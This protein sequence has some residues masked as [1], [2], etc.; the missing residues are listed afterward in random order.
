MCKKERI[1]RRCMCPGKMRWPS[2]SEP[3]C[4]Y[5]RKHN[6]SMPAG[7]GTTTK[8]YWGDSM[9]G[10]YCWYEDNADC[11]GEKYAHQV[12][13]KK[14]NAYGLYDMSGN[15]WEWCADWY[16]SGYYG[17]S[18]GKN[19]IN[20]EKSSPR[21]ARGGGWYGSAGSCRAAFRSYSSADY[22]G[23]DLG[24]RVASPAP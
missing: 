10:A 23:N 6:G 9:D 4:V 2:V 15:V 7:R 14:A 19:P 12:G 17:K 3:G 18:I 24:F 8:Y 13:Q 11:K 1:I 16:D 5:Q 21:V 22:R 20:T